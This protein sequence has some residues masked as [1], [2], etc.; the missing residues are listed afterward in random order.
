LLRLLSP[1]VFMDLK[2]SIHPAALDLILDSA[3]NAAQKGQSQYSTPIELAATLAADLPLH[4]NVIVD[5]TCG[6]CQLLT[7]TANK[8]T[9]F[10]LG[11][12]CRS[13]RTERPALCEQSVGQR[14]N[15]PSHPSGLDPIV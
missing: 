3:S 10:I 13:A 1:F 11:C 7:G 4:R 15:C 8:S 6:P 9:N 12:D 5:L 14:Q 2:S